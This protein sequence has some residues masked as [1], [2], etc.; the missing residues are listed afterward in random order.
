MQ[1]YLPT[2]FLVAT[3]TFVVL[4]YVDWQVPG[5][6]SNVFPLYLP[7][8]LAVI[9]G[10]LC[11]VEPA[12]PIRKQR[13]SLPLAV[14]IG[15]ILGLILF[16]SFTIFGD[17]QFLLILAVIITPVLLVKSIQDAQ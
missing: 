1:K 10:V 3:L 8:L 13:W 2:A 14:V 12:Q 16:P 9:L 6:V 7:L 5:F 17:W 15:L 11:I 4:L